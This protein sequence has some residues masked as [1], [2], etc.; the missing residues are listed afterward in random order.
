[1]DPWVVAITV[2]ASLSSGGALVL[3]ILSDAAL[4]LTSVFVAVPGFIALVGLTVWARR[5]Q[6]TLFL[7]RLRSGAIAG[8]L[9]T[10]AYDIVRWA[11]EAANLV[12]I[13]S[14][15][16]I[17]IFGVGLTGRPLDDGRSIAAGWTFHAV[18]GIGFALAYFFL[19]AGRRWWLGVGYALILE[20]WMISLYPGWLG[21][22]MNGEFFSVSMLGHVA[23]GAVLGRLAERAR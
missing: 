1:L 12:S 14:F 16:A 17:R 22:S 4:S 7:A 9:A 21:F 8:V 20:V 2:A 5:D 18:N 15:Q 10:A 6:Q 13:N 3:A 11:V 23:Y 19:A